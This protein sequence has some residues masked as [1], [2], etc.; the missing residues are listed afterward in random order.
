MTIMFVLLANATILLSLFASVLA[1]AQDLPPDVLADMH[2]L[3][4][5]NAMEAGDAQTALQ[6]FEQI[7]LLETERPPQFAFFYGKLLV[8]S[9]TMLDDLLKGESLLKQHVM[10]VEKSAWSYVPALEL[11]HT[12][13]EKLHALDPQRGVASLLPASLDDETRG[14]L[15]ILLYRHPHF[16]DDGVYNSPHVLALTQAMLDPLS[17]IDSQEAFGQSLAC[18]WH[19][20][21]ARDR[22]RVLP[23]LVKGGADLTV[24][25]GGEYNVHVLWF[26]AI[27][28]QVEAVRALIAA[29]VDVDVRN[30]GGR[31]W[32]AL[33]SIAESVA[34]KPFQA[35]SEINE[36]R[37][38]ILHVAELLITAGADVVPS[39]WK[40]CNHVYYKRE[41]TP[42]SILLGA[43]LIEAYPNV[44]FDFEKRGHSARCRDFIR[45]TTEKAMS[46]TALPSR[47]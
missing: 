45:A 44:T 8:E 35:I 40:M 16:C 20:M 31:R 17:G 9:A 38:N 42:L 22:W 26:A 36:Y 29:G 7:E 10:T 1:V 27:E 43:L 47:P 18:W 24:R 12:A 30:Q 46:G 15:A 33:R 41:P 2:L 37:N 28:G 21:R 14:A 25:A 23:L 3:N 19:D 4:A 32:T 11:I 34:E 39:F 5:R 6:A 13:A